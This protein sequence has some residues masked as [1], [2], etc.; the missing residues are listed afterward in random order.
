MIV[1][2]TTGDCLYTL[3]DI[4]RT[5]LLTEQAELAKFSSDIASKLT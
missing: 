2:G 1:L 4:R 5:E 3:V